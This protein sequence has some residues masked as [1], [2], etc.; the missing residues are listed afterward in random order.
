MRFSADNDALKV[1]CRESLGLL[2]RCYAVDATRSFCKRLEDYQY[3][4]LFLGMR[5]FR[6]HFCP[7]LASDLFVFLK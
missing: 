2:R 6:H 4:W 7:F 3:A 5:R 1:A